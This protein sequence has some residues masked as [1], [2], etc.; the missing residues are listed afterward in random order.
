MRFDETSL[1]SATA[2]LENMEEAEPSSAQGGMMM[3]QEAMGT[4]HFLIL[5]HFWVLGSIT[6]G[7]VLFCL[8]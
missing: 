1:L 4:S 7:H 3:G 2:W 5:Y 6:V 8:F